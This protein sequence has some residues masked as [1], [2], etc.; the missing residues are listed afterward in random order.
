MPL[1]NFN[2]KHH[3]THFIFNSLFTAI[4]FA[5]I[6]VFD[7]IIDQHLENLPYFHKDKHPYIKGWVHAINIFAIYMI[8]SYIFYYIFGW[9]N[10]C[11]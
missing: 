6:L 11:N 7:D 2:I 4:T 3:R 1:F 9:G 10:G 8:I 5:I